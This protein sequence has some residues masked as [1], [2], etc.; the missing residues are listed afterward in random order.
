MADGTT[1]T[2]IPVN[3]RTSAGVEIATLT[4]TISGALPAGNNNIGDVDVVTLPALPA[5]TNNIGDV[6]VLTLPALPAGTNNIGDVDVLTVPADPFGANADAAVAAGATGSIQAKLRRVTQGLEDLKTLIVLAAGNNN[7][8]DVDIA[9]GPTGASAL[10]LQ[11]SAAHGASDAGGPVKTGSVAIAH[12]SNPSA[13]TAGQRT[14]NYA[15][16]AGIPFHIGGHPNV[17]T[18][19]VSYTSAQTDTAIITVGS[20]VK[21]V[22]TALMVTADAANSVDVAV[23]IGFGT[24]N[25]PTGAGVVGSHP[26]IPASS[27]GGF[28]RGDGSGIIGIGADNE[29]LRITS[30]VATGGSIEVNVS[31]YTIES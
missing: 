21:I 25:T 16:R 6:D 19:R 18:L 3:L 5:G 28:S 13:V 27:G 10:Q 11:G 14:D 4:A 24:A 29:D 8:G 23:R 30:E 17:Q 2:P 1:Q 7:I 15:N 9:S 20:G 12:G 31:Y 26:G 22:V